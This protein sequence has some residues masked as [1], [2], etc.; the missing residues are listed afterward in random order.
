MR[1]ICA[2]KVRSAPRNIARDQGLSGSFGAGLYCAFRWRSR[3]CTTSSKSLTWRCT[4]SRCSGV[5]ADASSAFSRAKICSTVSILALEGD[6]RSQ[7]RA[8]N[9]GTS[10]GVRI[11]RK[12]KI[13]WAMMKRRRSRDQNPF[14]PVCQRQRILLPHVLHSRNRAQRTRATRTSADSNRCGLAGIDAGRGEEQP[15]GNGQA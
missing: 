13:L 12:R 5:F 9:P 2:T 15:R 7:S 10:R 11:G 14:L 4:S 3:I 6:R 8:D 1:W